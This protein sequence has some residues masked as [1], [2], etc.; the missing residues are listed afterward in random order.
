MLTGTH[1]VYG[2]KCYTELSITPHTWWGTS[3]VRGDTSRVQHRVLGTPALL[4]QHLTH[5]TVH[6]TLNNLT[7]IMS[8]AWVIRLL[9]HSNI[10][11]CISGF[12]WVLLEVRALVWTISAMR[13]WWGMT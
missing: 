10:A 9:P 8:W 11:T 12:R 1:I 5:Y 2:A 13:R 3:R 7:R 6:D 4:T